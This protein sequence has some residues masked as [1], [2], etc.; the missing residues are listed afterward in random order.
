MRRGQLVNNTPLQVP[1]IIQAPL[2]F[3][4]SN[5]L[6]VLKL[7]IYTLP[8]MST[9]N[10]KN[11]RQC[12]CWNLFNLHFMRNLWLFCLTKMSTGNFILGYFF[13]IAFIV[14]NV[15]IYD[16]YITSNC[17]CFPCQTIWWL[18]TKS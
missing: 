14:T 7:S 10:K 11:V 17:Q 1:R 13:F 4:R 16:D 3:I 9:G 2:F 15:F 5:A 6:T 8:T 12:V 18:S